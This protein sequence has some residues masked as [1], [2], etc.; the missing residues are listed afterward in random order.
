L[1]KIRNL[2]STTVGINNRRN[3]KVVVENIQFDR[4]EEF[5]AR[6]NKII[7]AKKRDEILKYSILAA[8][9]FV[10][11]TI[12]AVELN[13]RWILVREELMKKRALAAKESMDTGVIYEVEMSASDRE[14]LEIQKH[15]MQ[16][17]R[18]DPEMVSNL[19][20]AWLLEE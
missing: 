1:D 19:L 8:I 6:R 5:K 11:L 14:K 2:V 12:I 18:D 4:R 3:D 10:L 15:A 16:A 13:K 20:K 7:I 9:I 17:A